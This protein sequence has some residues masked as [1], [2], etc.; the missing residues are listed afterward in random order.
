MPDRLDHLPD[1]MQHRCDDCGEIMLPNSGIVSHCDGRGFNHIRP[2]LCEA[3]KE[4]MATLPV[5]VNI[6][7]HA[8][9]EARQALGRLVNE[10]DEENWNDEVATAVFSALSSLDRGLEADR[11]VSWQP[12]AEA[13]Q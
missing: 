2:E 5:E 11:L 8:L 12:P 13:A 10:C 4:R 7:Q 3:Q 9:E 1:W 6:Q